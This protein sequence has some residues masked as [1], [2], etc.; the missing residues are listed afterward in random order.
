[1]RSLS[2]TLLA[3]Q[4]QPSALPYV[5]AALSDASGDTA[6]IRFTRHYTGSEGEYFSAVVGAGDGSLIR[7]RIDP[8][9]KVLYTQ[10]VAS[11]GPSST[12]SSWTSQGTVSASGGV[13][14]AA[15][16]SS[17]FLFY[18]DVDTLTLK[19]KESTDNG[20]SYGSA[21]TVATAGTAVTHL[22]AAIAPGGDRLLLWN[23]GATLYRSRYTGS[24][25]ARTAW[26][27][28]VASITGIAC[29]HFLDWSVVV[30][31]TEQTTT[32]AKVW[33]CLFGDGANQSPNTW[34]SLREV[35]TATAGSNVSFRS[36]ALE[37]L[38]SWRLFFVEKYT[39]SLAYSRL[40]WTTM[41]PI[42]L[43]NQEFWREPLAFDYPATGSAQTADY[44]V[45]VTASTL[46]GYLWLSAAAG[47]WSGLSPANP[48][49]DV[50][51]GVI[52]AAVDLSEQ[53]G[54]VRLTLRND[55][56]SGNGALGRYSA[57]GSGALG[58]LQ[59]GTM[60]K[61]ST[62]YYTTVGAEASDGP[63]YWVESVEQVT[64]AE[65]R[66]IV[67]A[68]DAWWLLEQWRARRQFVWAAGVRTVS[69]LVQFVCARA[70]VYHNTISASQALTT[71][72]PAFTIS[73]GESG[74]TAVRRLLALVPDV[75][76]VQGPDLSF[77]YPLANDGV[78]YALG[79]DHT[80]VAGRYLD[81]GAPLNRLRV[82]G[83]GVF[84]EAFDFADIESVGER[85]GQVLD[86]N[87]TTTTLAGDR[88]AYGLRDAAILDNRDEVRL[89]GVCCGIELYD[90]VSVTDP[91]AGLAAENRRV[92]ALSWRYSTGLQARYDM[93]L[94]LGST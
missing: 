83:A 41:S 15:A 77:R 4:K 23:E 32:H 12:F 50:S 80:L 75:G 28:T 58:A 1:M 63:Q 67:H 45:G 49:L 57:Y 36:P 7:A 38:Q 20:V 26:S 59:R 8:T 73:P 40:Q 22:A 25:G 62:G 47:V 35:T 21:T 53:D 92:L 5:K 79:T 34:S 43:F 69:Q 54:R 30:C 33:T 61:L 39:G 74:K 18:V 48:D 2:S 90:V 31:G 72:Q 14:L 78:D 60:L 9:T 11:P 13:A 17:V 42:S 68:R 84:N 56:A 29:V 64:G 10:R 93:T 24:W 88:A 94:T 86:L 87:L 71:L 82:L 16:G 19:V 91:Q 51:D 27:N 85:V 37:M 52:E 89:A 6:R 44:G 81:T 70:G 76:V 65:S 55:A 46:G 3:A 66:L